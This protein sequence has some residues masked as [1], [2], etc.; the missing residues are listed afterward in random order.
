MKHFYK[1][2]FWIICLFLLINSL[3]AEESIKEKTEREFKRYILSAHPLPV[4]TKYELPML[5]LAE[6]KNE[7]YFLNV[8]MIIEEVQGKLDMQ[9]ESSIAVSPVNPKFLI[10]SSVDYRAESSTWVYISKDGGKTWLNRHFGHPFENWRSTNDPSVAFDPNGYGYLVY[11][12]FPDVATV[13]GAMENG[14]FIAKTTDE[15]ETWKAHIPVILHKGVLTLDSAFDDK[16]YI[17]VDNSPTSPYHKHLYIPWKRVTPRDSATQIFLSKSTDAGETWSNPVPVSYRVAGSS[18]DTTYGQ[19]FP[20]ATTSPEGDVYVVWNH[21]IVHGIGFAKSTDGGNTFS[22]PRIIQ[23]YN[24]FGKTK[25]ISGGGE[26]IYRHSVKGKVRAEAYPVVICD[27]T[28][29]VNRGK[30]YLCWAADEI[31]NIYFSYSEDKG[32]TWSEPIFV[33]S[34]TTNDQFWQ[35]MSIDPKNGDLAIMYLDS[36]ND[37]ANIMVEC[38]AAYSSDGGKSW[39]DR[40]VSD[41]SSDL[42]LNPFAANAFAGDYSGCAFFD[43]KIYPSWVDMRNAVKNIFDSDVLTALINV[44]SPMPPENF[45]GHTQ[46]ERIKEIKLDWIAPTERSFGQTLKLGEYNYVLYRD[47][48]FLAEIASDNTEYFDSGLIPYEKY[49]YKI[50]T[51]SGADTSIFRET[52]AFAGGAKKPAAPEI[53]S[54]KAGNG[55]DAELYVKMPTLREDNVTPLVNLT[56]L[57]VYK[58]N[59][60]ALEQTVANTDT[61]KIIKFN[62]QNPNKGYYTYKVQVADS[63]TPSN[64]SDFSKEVCFYS[65]P[66]LSELDDNFDIP[67]INKY[68][69]NNGWELTNQFYYSPPNCITESKS[70][71]YKSNETN[72]ITMYPILASK[73]HYLRFRTAAIVHV[74]DS[75]IVEI[76]K[77]LGKSWSLLDAFN[78]NSYPTWKDKQLT[79]EDWLEKVYKFDGI[80]EE[81]DTVVVRFRMKSNAALEDDGWYIDNF[82]FGTIAG[83]V[84]YNDYIQ[85]KIEIS[86][87]PAKD[88]I[89]VQLKNVNNISQYS[90]ELFSSLGTKVALSESMVTTSNDYFIVDV[91]CLSQGAYAVI[92]ISNSGKKLTKLF[93]VVR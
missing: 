11:G 19:S 60:L 79:Q 76:S 55:N 51:C 15:G 41:I 89:I 1:T 52:F 75:A 29:G 83:D 4:N 68:T 61:G 63:Y 20:L 85:E 27:T 36:R 62:I 81:Q 26:P 90:I 70:G 53:V 65:G 73:S 14:V 5:P 35:W 46:P 25:D 80:I 39:I 82:Y 3:K 67:V 57:A 74:S 23:F 44:R 10:G 34:D 56:R 92:A 32:V 54:F 28:N 16:Y 13:S 87:N 91:S 49:E 93:A 31:P 43:G 58:D 12:G 33:S 42:R 38:Y 88:K 18:E 84:N 64:I 50:A 78:I 45:I 72:F 22:E 66:F 24:I 48:K 2:I 86:P 9:N 30:I 7:S 47:G 71:K 37:P 17:S 69:I 77:D 40:R 6:N 21:G 8:N 59:A